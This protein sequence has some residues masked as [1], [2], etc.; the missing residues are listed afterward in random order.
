[1][2]R[3]K[4]DRRGLWV[5]SEIERMSCETAIIQAIDTAPLNRGL[6]G[7]AWL[8]HT[9]NVPIVMGDDIALFDDEGA[10][11]YEVHLLFESRGRAAVASA[12]EAY[13]Q[14]FEDRGAEFLFSLVPDFRRDAKMVARW[15]GGKFVGKRDTPNGLCELFVLSKEMWSE[16]QCRF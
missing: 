5:R 8:A 7:V 4:Q 14:M 6:S 16:S 11:T 2:R 10:G 3:Q 13:R 1:V 15:S 12:K 9:G